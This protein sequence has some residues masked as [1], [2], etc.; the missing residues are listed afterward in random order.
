MYIYTSRALINE[1]ILIQAGSRA[2]IESSW[3]YISFHRL[4]I[5]PN[6]VFTSSSFNNQFEYE[7]SLFKP[8]LS[9]LTSSPARL[10]H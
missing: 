7:S 3:V 4:I 5:E 10:H 8:I 2:L 1:S 6:F 9:K